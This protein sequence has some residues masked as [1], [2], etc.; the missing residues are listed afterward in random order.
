MFSDII[1]KVNKLSAVIL[2]EK[3]IGVP[4]IS[5]IAEYS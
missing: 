5:A 4:K 3:I 2:D 1:L